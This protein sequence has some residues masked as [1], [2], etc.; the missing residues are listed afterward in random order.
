MY[1]IEPEYFEPDEWKGG[2]LSKGAH[3]PRIWKRL[4]DS[5]GSIVSKQAGHLPVSKQ[6]NVIDA[7][8]IGLFALGRL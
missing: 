4:A 7:I 1:G 8:G 3:H 5:E 2:T 6:H